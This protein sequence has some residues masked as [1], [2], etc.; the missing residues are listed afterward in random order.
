MSQN[1]IHLLLADDDKDDCLLFKE[2]L[3]ELPVAAELTI[4][5]NG[6]ELMRSLTKLAGGLPSVIFLDLNMPRK[7]GFECLAEIKQSETLKD[8]TVVIFSTSLDPEVVNMHYT[9]GA[10]YYIRKP[11]E[12]PRL[13]EVIDTA[14]TLTTNPGGS[15]TE[16]EKFI[17]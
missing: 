1:H 14:I 12:F 9:Q 3:E 4:V 5:D 17:I 2:A 13:K 16:K 8:L 7:N 11:S 6:E 10:Q 15:P